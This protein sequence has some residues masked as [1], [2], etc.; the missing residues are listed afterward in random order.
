M[1]KKI[2]AAVVDSLRTPEES[3]RVKF[4]GKHTQASTERSAD[5][6]YVDQ[7]LEAEWQKALEAFNAE[8]TEKFIDNQW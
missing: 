8:E 2:K 4:E 7:S 5:G 6:A 1:F 3:F